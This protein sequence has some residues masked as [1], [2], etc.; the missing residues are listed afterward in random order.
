MAATDDARTSD[1]SLRADAVRNRL[2]I[3]EAAQALF[4]E[5]GIDVPLDEIAERAEVGAGTLYRRFPTREDLLEAVFEDELRKWATIAEEALACED[6]WV[7]FSTFIERICAT[8][9]TDRGF[10]DLI[11]MKLP[12]SQVT[13]SLCARQTRAL[14][15]LVLRAQEAG[16]LREDFVVEDI[17]LFLMANAGVSQVTHCAAP[18]AWRRLVAFL[19]E[20]CRPANAGPLPAAPT[21]LQTERAM[22]GHATAMGVIPRA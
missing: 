15:D 12:T 9:A 7:G 2:R 5:R 16:A 8:M 21:A 14:A 6:P 4:E 19:L 20:A 11:I 1:R 18:H 13:A 10:S 22:L 17:F 3:V